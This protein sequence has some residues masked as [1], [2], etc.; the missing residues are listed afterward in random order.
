MDEVM[1][2]R[3]HQTL[4]PFD[5]DC[6]LTFEAVTVA[7]LQQLMSTLLTG[8][9]TI[10]AKQTLYT[11]DD[12]HQHDGFVT[13]RQVMDWMVLQAVCESEAAMIASRQGDTYVHRAFYPEDH[14]F[15]LR[16]DVSDDGIVGADFTGSMDLTASAAMITTMQALLPLDVRSLVRV[17]TAKVYFDGKHAG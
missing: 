10:Y 8:L 3:W 6:L 16:Y 11:F 5:G 14:G 2:Q 9:K 17:E 12:W 7:Q 4:S 13:E 15:L 1:N